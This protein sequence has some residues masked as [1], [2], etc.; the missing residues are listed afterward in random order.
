MKGSKT[1]WYGDGIGLRIATTRRWRRSG[2]CSPDHGDLLAPRS[3]GR[4]TFQGKSST[5]CVGLAQSGVGLPCAGIA[6]AFRTQESCVLCDQAPEEIDHL[7]ISCVFSRMVCARTL[8][9]I[10]QV[11]LSP[12]NDP[13]FWWIICKEK[14]QR[15]F[16]NKF[17]NQESCL[18]TIEEECKLWDLAGYRH[19]RRMI[20]L[21]Q[22]SLVS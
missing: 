15:T 12:K 21:S 3:Y 20:N 17:R 6:M 18:Q 11:H 16:R 4:L 1:D 9:V 5:S 10:G 19:L 22:N 2:C 8:S 7:L 13:C 14:N